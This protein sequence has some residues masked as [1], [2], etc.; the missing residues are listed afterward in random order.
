[1][2]YTQKEMLTILK[3]KDEEESIDIGLIRTV[4][5]QRPSNMIYC[6]TNGKL[7]GVISMGDLLRACR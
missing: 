6:E 4:I 5:L 7:T 3:L 1:M 2:L